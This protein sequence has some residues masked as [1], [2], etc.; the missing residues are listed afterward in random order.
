MSGHVLSIV[1][2]KGGVG[3]TFI[4]HTFAFGLNRLGKRVLMVDMD[5]Q[6]NL[7]RVSGCLDI[8]QDISDVL[9]DHQPV[10][11]AIKPVRAQQ[12]LVPLDIIRGSKY[13]SQADRQIGG[14][15]EL[16]IDALDQVRNDYDYIVVD[17]SPGL[18]IATL[19]ALVASDSVIIPVLSEITSF[20][21]VE[22][23]DEVF[24]GLRREGYTLDIA[25]LLVNRDS[26]TLLVTRE[27]ETS[28]QALALMLNTEIFKTRIREARAPV[29]GAQQAQKSIFD[30]APRHKIAQDCMSV[31][32][33]FLRGVERDG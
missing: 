28:L 29:K 8:E 19:N 18:G 31:I 22:I 12:S 2:L 4:A 20:D 16:L 24:W 6:C 13:L 30:F 32:E 15:A 9:I 25:G 14:Q 7:T 11:D 17:T 26:P 21:G 5:Y 27:V 10:R 23:L 1:A 3:K 33:E